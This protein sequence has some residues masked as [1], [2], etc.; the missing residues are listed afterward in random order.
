V[1]SLQDGPIPMY[2]A[3]AERGSQAGFTVLAR[4]GGDA[5]ALVRPLGDVIRGTHPQ[6]PVSGLTT[7]EAHLG[8]SLA[9][10]RAGASLMGAFSF[11]AL[12][13]ATLG[14]YAMVSFSVA[15]RAGE[16]GVRAA[17]GAGRTQLIG[18][19]VGESLVPVLLG[20]AAGL[21]GTWAAGPLL[22]GLL[23]GV[24]GRDPLTLG[25]T[26][27]LLVAV[28][29]VASWLPAWRA[30]RIDPVDALRAR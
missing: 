28:A 22:A 17:M 2:Y 4:T 27:L 16:M 26:A 14:V 29:T 8:E 5:A 13:L 23:F 1:G 19:V 25:G 9:D 6:L 24:G 11:L 3:S 30:S 18:M 10:A 15:G 20:V 21:A 7:M 12:L